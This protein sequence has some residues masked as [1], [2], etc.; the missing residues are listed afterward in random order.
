VNVPDMWT[1]LSL[2]A[3]PIVLI[4]LYTLQRYRRS[5]FTAAA[6]VDSAVTPGTAILCVD[7]AGHCTAAN[8]AARRLLQQ[9]PAEA[10]LSDC[11]RGGAQILAAV[12]DE[13]VVERDEVV[14]NQPSPALVH[15]RAVALRDRDDNFWGAAV[16]IDPPAFTAVGAPS[17]P[18]PR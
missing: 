16:F 9:L 5:W 8:P 7:P 6:R 15:V 1:W 10:R 3:A 13:G 2:G 18:F 14:V 12:A 11:L 17:G 4:E